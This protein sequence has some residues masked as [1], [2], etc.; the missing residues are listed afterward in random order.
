MRLLLLSKG[1]IFSSVHSE[2][3]LKWAIPSSQIV[4]DR[5]HH[6]RVLRSGQAG[7]LRRGE[8]LH[9]GKHDWIC[10]GNKDGKSQQEGGKD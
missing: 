10:N 1:R 7:I 3:M 5:I 6:G 2:D 9:Q 4:G 8:M